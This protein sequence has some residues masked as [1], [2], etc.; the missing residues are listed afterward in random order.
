MHET[1]AFIATQHSTRAEREIIKR[2]RPDTGYTVHIFRQTLNNQQRAAVYII[3]K[4]MS[5]VG[6]TA[7]SSVLWCRIVNVNEINLRKKKKT[8]TTRSCLCSEIQTPPS[9]SEAMNWQKITHS[10]NL[11]VNTRRRVYMLF[12]VCAFV[13]LYAC[14]LLAKTVANLLFTFAGRRSLETNE[15]WGCAIVW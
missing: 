2:K 10:I 3:N 12:F 13:C 4:P 15:P 1:C 14:Q 5:S 6:L 7:L 11:T 8:H 9:A